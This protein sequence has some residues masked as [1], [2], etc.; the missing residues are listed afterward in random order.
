MRTAPRSS[1]IAKA[2]AAIALAILADR[3]FYFQWIGATL[4]G[5]ALAWIVAVALTIPAVRHRPSARAA[6]LLATVFALILV[7]NPGLLAWTLFWVSLSSAA[8][9]ARA[10][11]GDAFRLA[12]R[13]LLHIGVGTIRLVSDVR[14]YLRV[15]V[16]GS[17]F[18]VARLASLLAL[19]VI[20]G[21]VFLALFA[22]ANPLIG[23]LV[24]G[25]EIGSPIWIV[26]H[27]LFAAIVLFAI[28]PSLRPHPLVSGMPLGEASLA[29]VEPRLPPATIILS[30]I[31]FN[32]V[33]ALQNVL[34][35]LFLW[36]GA[37]LPGTITMAD[38]AHRGAY[39]LIATALL[40]G[41]FVLVAM[42]PGSPSAGHRSVKLLV[43][44]WVLQNLLLVASSILRTLDYIG[45][46]SLTVLRLQAI[47]WMGLVGI[48]LVLI[49]WRL[50]RGKSA[51]WLINANAL[52]AGLT[53]LAFSV[54]DPA[55]VAAQWN[56]RH[57]KEAGGPG[58][59]ID[60]CYLRMQGS[61]ALLPLI[62]LE[63]KV[64]DLVTQDRVR[65]IRAETMMLL[66]EGQS[67]WHGWTYRN[68]RRLAAA[69][70]ALAPNPAKPL[71]AP[72]GR[73]CDG[74]R[75]DESGNPD[76]SLTVPPQV[77]IP[78]QPERRPSPESRRT[79]D[80]T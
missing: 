79:H 71:P 15:R 56:V 66:E 45:S 38:Y 50:L 44:L 43:T 48:G 70:A 11:Y 76:M 40:A 10:R 21:G 26:P 36:S 28:W 80:D 5:F 39:S 51:A 77:V 24:N 1:Y 29:M 27:F 41:L 7:D 68:A 46:Y 13:L 22:S 20:G 63:A 49:C 17:S 65:A 16:P 3:L 54:I 72:N 62:E 2:V 12:Q 4:G 18:G 30:L 78:G 14:R 67:D 52:F 73:F 34:D 23:N 35:I 59:E 64:T 37:R 61:S 58:A 53:L 69:R 31:T 25:V 19:P 32:A 47:A 9:L 60:L 42:R 6:A 74:A 33:F 8:I 55:A 75:Q 57:A